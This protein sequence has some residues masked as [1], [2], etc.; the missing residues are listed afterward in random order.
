MT[1][2][3]AHAFGEGGVVL[4]QV[5]KQTPCTATIISDLSSP[6]AVRNGGL[7]IIPR[8]KQAP[9]ISPQVQRRFSK[10]IQSASSCTPPGETP[11]FFQFGSC[12]PC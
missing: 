3:L 8:I 4:I 6:L 5:Q 10:N 7:K 1:G 9:L 2:G 12:H 11:S